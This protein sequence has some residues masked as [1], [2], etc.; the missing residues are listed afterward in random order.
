MSNL[1]IACEDC[2]KDYL[3]EEIQITEDELDEMI[4]EQS[5]TYLYFFYQCGRLS[6]LADVKEQ[7][8][9]ECIKD[10]Y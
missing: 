2:L 4:Q 3:E 10:L 5:G 8:E 6:A 7:L 1:A 9:K